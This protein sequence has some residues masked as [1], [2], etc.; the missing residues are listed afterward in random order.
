MTDFQFINAM[1]TEHR[2]AVIANDLMDHAKRQHHLSV[3][4]AHT[5][6]ETRAA[7]RHEREQNRVAALDTAL[8]AATVIGIALATWFLSSI[9]VG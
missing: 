5:R 8:M 9:G 3:H 1:S 2:I 7:N 6:I 4:K